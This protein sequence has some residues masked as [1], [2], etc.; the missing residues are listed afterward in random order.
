MKTATRPIGKQEQQQ[1]E[2]KK[3]V[4]KKEASMNQ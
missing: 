1:Q 2:N 3:S 4:N